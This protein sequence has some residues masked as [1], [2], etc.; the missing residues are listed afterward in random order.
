MAR[1]AHPKRQFNWRVDSSLIEWVRD[2]SDRLECS[3]SDIVTKAVE[4][5]RE[6]VEK[7]GDEAWKP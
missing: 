5:W 6:H 7:E 3:I 1:R 4:F 2:E